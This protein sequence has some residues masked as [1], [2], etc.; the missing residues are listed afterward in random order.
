LR[1]FLASAVWIFIVGGLAT[2]LNQRD[3]APITQS[4][5]IETKK[6][7][8][9]FSLL[10]TTTF[11]VEPD[12]FAI[13]IDD[14]DKPPALLVRLGNRDILRKTDRLDAGTPLRVDSLPGLITGENELYL[15]A[16]P[17]LDVSDATRN[18]NAVRVRVLRNDQIVA[19]KTFWSNL[20]G[21]VV[22]IFRFSISAASEEKED[23]DHN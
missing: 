22:G 2:Y 18:G 21:K 11:A 7:E 1:F 4:V 3:R 10:V 23:H 5:S 17:P 9:T 8:E 15:E 20:G 6:V 19:E 13:Q 16:N 14:T 12:P